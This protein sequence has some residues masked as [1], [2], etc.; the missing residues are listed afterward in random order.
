[1][2]RLLKSLKNENHFKLFLPIFRVFVCFHII[3]KIFINYGST[4]IFFDDKFVEIK[5]G[6]YRSFDWLFNTQ[7]LE[8][9]ILLY[10]LIFTCVLYAFGIGRW[11]TALLVFIQFYLYTE[12][13]ALNGN[14]GDNYLF[15][16][17]FYLIF[18]DSYYYLC[19]KETVKK[20]SDYLI[21]NIACYSIMIHLCLIYFVSA[22]HKIHAE[23]WFN[24][25][26]TYYILNLERYSSP[27][28]HYFSKNA[29]IVIFSTYFTILIELLFPF[30]VWTKRFR[31]PFLIS[32]LSLHI[33]IY[34]FMMIYD[35]EILFMMVYGF[36]LT[37]QEWK[38][39]LEKMNKLKYVSKWNIKLLKTDN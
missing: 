18:A 37:N 10:F 24:G 34:L 11:F 23:E 3:K 9:P 14:G 12:A 22:I 29:F 32:G 25:V 7:I 6:F 4:S 26:A 31:I 17:L 19:L 27:F 35:F 15:F 2:A 38:L 28:N 8:I 33:G 20:K 39:I 16:I 36:F 30:L 5:S 1:M 13:S 21:S